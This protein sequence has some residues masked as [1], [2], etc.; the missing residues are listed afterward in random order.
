MPAGAVGVVVVGETGVVRSLQPG[1]R[2]SV[3]PTNTIDTIRRRNLR[4]AEHFIGEI[5]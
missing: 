2:T 3:A 1:C 4:P 5:L